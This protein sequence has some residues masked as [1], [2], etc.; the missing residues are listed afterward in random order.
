LIEKCSFQ[1]SCQFS[2]KSGVTDL[3]MQSTC[4]P[5]LDYFSVKQF[6][7]KTLDCDNNLLQTFLNFVVSSL[8]SAAKA[9]LELFCLSNS[10]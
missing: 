1:V 7:F 10:S 4:W 3:S 9:F 8:L 6:E 5:P 2:A